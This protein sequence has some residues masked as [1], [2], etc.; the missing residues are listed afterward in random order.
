MSEDSNDF[1][2]MARSAADAGEFRRRVIV[3][4][5]DA[6][7]RPWWRRLLDWARR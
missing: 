2:V 3:A 7:P 5:R 1:V 4:L 6:A